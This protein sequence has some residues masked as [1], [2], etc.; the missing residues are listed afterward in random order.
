MTIQL[1]DLP[2]IYEQ[3]IKNYHMLMSRRVKDILVVASLYD[4]CIINQD[5]RLEERIAALGRD[6]A[7]HRPPRVT[8]VHS[9]AEALTCLEEKDFD[10]VITTLQVSDA[11]AAELGAAIQSRWARIP[12][13]LLVHSPEAVRHLRQGGTIPT[14]IDQVFVWSHDTEQVMAM[15]QCAEDMLNVRQDTQRCR[16]PVILLVGASGEAMTAMMPVVYRELRAQTELSVR[17]GRDTEVRRLLRKAR[18]RVVLAA[19]R[20]AA[21]EALELFAPYLV[22]VIG[23]WKPHR[24]HQDN[25]PYA[26]GADL[27]LS[28]I[29][30]Q[31]ADLPILWMDVE[32]R[33]LDQVH[34]MG[35]V[36]AHAPGE[37]AETA[38]ADF[39][40]RRLGF[41]AMEIRDRQGRVAARAE[42]LAELEPLISTLPEEV[43]C[44]HIQNHDFIRW[45]RGRGEI[46]LAERLQALDAVT[47][48]KGLRNSCREILLK[49]FRARRINRMQETIAAFDRETFDPAQGFY[50]IGRGSMG[51]KARGLLFLASQLGKDQTWAQQFPQIDMVVPRALVV[52]TDI[53]DAYIDT[54]DLQIPARTQM[55]DAEIAERFAAAPLPVSVVNDLDAYLARVDQPLAVRSSSLLEDSLSRPYAGIYKT[56]MLPNDHPERRVRLD[57]LTA[58]VKLIYASTFFEEPRAFAARTQQK[59]DEEK[60]AVVIQPV[61]GHH[62]GS[63]YLPAVSG[64][65]QSYNYY[66]MAPMQP[67]DGI[68]SIAVGL[69]KS[70]VDG[71]R[72]LRFCPRYPQNLPQFS[73]V[74]DILDNTQRY[75]YGLKMKVSPLALGI[76]A[77]ATLDKR[78]IGDDDPADLIHLSASTYMPEEHRIKD[79]NVGGGYPVVTFAPLLKYERLPLPAILDGLLTAGRKG[80][81]RA[82]DLEF[83]I[84]YPEGMAGRAQLSILQIRPMA[85]PTEAEAIAILEADRRHAFC[86]SENAL[87]NGVLSDLVDIVYVK[88]ADFDPGKTPEIAREIARINAELTQNAQRYLLIGPG[89]WGSADPWLGIPVNWAD[90]SGAAA[91]V[92]TTHEAFRVDPSQGS[93]FF[94]NLTSLGMSY[95][96]ITA[97][98]EDF[99]KLGW[100]ASHPVMRVTRFLSHIRLERPVVIKVDGRRS[101]GIIRDSR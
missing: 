32:P 91:I 13:M 58:A 9:G 33:L 87:G 42:T 64:V 93:H 69:G 30:E 34:S 101:C 67:E 82:V 73:T 22:G 70:V 46:L 78:E 47:P 54:N 26:E 89:R 5:R 85:G 68:A 81:G 41:G 51:G 76:D 60:M 80:L 75:Y 19:D 12:V 71:E 90:I 11:Q 7:H 40:R 53:F 61:V 1:D 15:I 23:A 45:L 97:D 39:M 29:R 10:L 99:I 36:D 84:H 65:A 50:R 21:T 24:A 17:D 38:V 8:W 86:Y 31:Y 98:S 49:L 55:S 72:V 52:T 37:A 96:N 20:P 57:E 4:A 63:L 56:Y 77:D 14:G 2:E 16:V 27:L 74:D 100:F 28:A 3:S 25:G 95:F 94:H 43:L 48:D 6:G 92:E 35:A 66:P 44:A 18:P 62:H 59:P 79:A 88:P 83:C